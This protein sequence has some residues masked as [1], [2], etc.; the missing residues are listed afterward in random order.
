MFISAESLA[1]LFT[2]DE[3]TL[4]QATRFIKAFAGATVPMIVFFSLSGSLQGA[5][6][7]RVPLLARGSG[8]FIFMLCFSYV[9]GVVLGAGPLGT[10]VGIALSYVWMALVILWAFNSGNCAERAA[11]LIKERGTTG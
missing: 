5:S 4:L 8:L 2:D 9:T 1:G 7:T 11:G 6:E 10:Y 3:E